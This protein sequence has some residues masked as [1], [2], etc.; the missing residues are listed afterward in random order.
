MELNSGSE[1]KSRFNVC[2]EMVRY[3]VRQF[4]L[5][6]VSPML[7]KRPL[8]VECGRAIRIGIP[9]VVAQLLNVSMGFVDTVMTGNYSAE[10]L[11]AVSIWSCP[12]SCL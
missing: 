2:L 10:A 5:S 9:I 3:G 8:I 7:L 12:W 6:A 4:T 11:A 1:R